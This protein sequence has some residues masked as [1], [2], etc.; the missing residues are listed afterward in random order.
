V[1][2]P[3]QTLELEVRGAVAVVRMARERVRNA[4]N[5]TMVDELEACVKRLGADPEVRAVV[6]A[7]R[8]PVFCAGA[9]LDWMSRMADFSDEQNRSDALRLALMLRTI[10]ECPRPTIAR[11]HGDA[12]GGGLGLICACDV[13]IGARTATFCLSETRLG[14]IPAA[15]SPYVLRAIG[16]RQALRYFQTAERFDSTEALRIGLLHAVV[17]AEQLDA[18]LRETLEAVLQAS[19][20]AMLAAKR[21]VHEVTERPIDDG[22]LAHTAERIAQARSSADGREGIRAFLGKRKPRWQLTLP[23]TEPDSDEEEM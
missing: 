6:L 9:D 8:G 18:R 20:Q 23:P 21:L 14:L 4:F 22:L 15:I 3:Y 2:P 11:V 16:Q 1:T 12:F 17:P 7:G 13:A 10:Y 19:P 5:E